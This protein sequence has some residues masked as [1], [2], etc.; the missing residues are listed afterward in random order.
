MFLVTVILIWNELTTTFG[1]EER[2]GGVGDTRHIGGAALSFRPG[3][4]ERT[5]HR[6]DGLVLGNLET[7]DVVLRR[8]VVVLAAD[9]AGAGAARLVER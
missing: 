5:G 1:N 4:Q 8:L 6:R 7:S 3:G 9:P 2:P